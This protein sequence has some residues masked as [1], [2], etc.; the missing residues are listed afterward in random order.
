M[1]GAS[2]GGDPTV[3]STDEEEIHDAILDEGLSRLGRSWRV[4]LMTGLLGGIEVSLGV[5]AFLVTL[6]ETGSHLLAGLAFSVGF[7]ALYLAHSELFTEGFLYPIVAV[8]SGRGTVGRLLRLWGATLVANL[9]G[10]WVTVWLVVRAY[11]ELTPT[12]AESAHRFLDQ[13]PGVRGLALAL[14]AGAGITLMTR[15]QVGAKSETGTIAAA[16]AGAY[17]LAGMGL[18]HSVL[19]SVLIFGAIHAGVDGVTYGDWLGWIWWVI[20]VNVVGGLLLVT[21][22]R[23][24]RASEI[25]RGAAGG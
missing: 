13:G 1:T 3:A 16:V 8:V 18:F 4:L 21:G 6:H 12:L 14:L 5:L 17:L 7:I 20:P 24:V 9:V 11:P 25:R 19:D 10:G 23:L 15:M 2:R 22:P